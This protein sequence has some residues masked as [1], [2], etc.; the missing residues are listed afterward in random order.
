MQGRFSRLELARVQRYLPLSLSKDLRDYVR[1]AVRAGSAS[2][3]K[4]KLKGN[5][6]D[7]PFA[8]TRQ[9]EFRIS[10]N[11]SNATYAYVPASPLLAGKLHWPVFTQ[12][13]GELVIDQRALYLNGGAL[14]GS[15]TYVE[16]GIPTQT[17]GGNDQI[18]LGAATTATLQLGGGND[19]V[20]AVSNTGLNAGDFIDFGSGTDSLVMTGNGLV[21]AA[22]FDN[23][24]GLEQLTLANTTTNV[25]IKAHDKLV[26]S[27]SI[28]TVSANT[29]TT[30]LLDFDG[31]LELDGAFQIFSGGGN[32]RITT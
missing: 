18:T 13:T 10:A 29:L 21:L 26:E 17:G 30:G 19:R 1:E 14:T 20:T 5:L 15:L 9:G 6:H 32:D 8:Q 12:L 3:I 31:R 16:S 2:D 7:F 22:H 27:G 28:L 11:V 24:R 23:I 25:T 4:L